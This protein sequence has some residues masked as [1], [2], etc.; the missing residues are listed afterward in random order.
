MKILS[1]EEEAAHYKVVVKGGLIGGSAGVY[2][3]YGPTEMVC[4]CV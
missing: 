3:S 4:S 1:K 2:G